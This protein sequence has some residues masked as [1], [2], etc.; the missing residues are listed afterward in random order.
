MCGITVSIAIGKRNS[1][2][3]VNGS[4]N[5]AAKGVVNGAVHEQTKNGIK[6]SFVS[7][8][9]EENLNKSLDLLAHRGPDA[10]GIWINK[11]GTVGLAHNR[12]SIND[13]SPDGNQPLHSDDGTIHAVVNGEIYDYDRIRAMLVR[14]HGYRFKSR[15]DSELVVAL[16]K[17]FGAPGFLEH[18]RGEF[19]FVIYD[20]RTERI[21]AA[22]DRFGI[23]P[24]FWTI[25]GEGVNRRLL[26][27]AEAK[28]FLALGWK[29]KWDVQA[30]FDSGWAS[31]DRTLF[32]GVR[33]VLPSYW[34]EVSAQGE[35]QHHRYWDIDYSDKNEVDTRSVEEM[36]QGVR[37]RLME[38]IRLRLRADVPVGILLSGGLDSS[39]VAGIV[40]HLVREEGAKHGN[41]DPTDRISCFT[42]QFPGA[43]YDESEIA[44]RTAKWLG[45]QIYKQPMNEAAMATHFADSAYYAEHHIFD[46]N[47]TAKFGLSLLP[48]EKGYKVV[49]TG[50]GSDE[51]FAGYPPFPADFLREPDLSFPSVAPPL[52][53]EM[54]KELQ[55]A[56]EHAIITSAERAGF[57]MENSEGYQQIGDE[58]G[59]H[60]MLNFI[61]RVQPPQ[62]LFAPWV[63]QQKWNSDVGTTILR[64]VEP[65]TAEKIANKWHSLH[66]SEYL[67]TR[68]A[69]P[70][71][72]L[73]GIGDRSEMGH[74]IEG[75]P[76]FLDHELSAY[77]NGLPPSTKL[78]YLP[79]SVRGGEER[80]SK[81]WFDSMGGPF[82]E[83]WILREAAKPFIT[84]EQYE[85]KKHPLS[86]PSKWSKGG[87]LNRMLEETC[88]RKAVEGL[89]FI[90]FNVVENALARGFGDD[91]DPRSFRLL[92]FVATWVILSQRFGMEKATAEA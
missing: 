39:L 26:I 28:A 10:R 15:S 84:Q 55:E 69:L 41:L 18:L 12:L 72:L 83:K 87:P 91:A 37:E 78:R 35:M 43:E 11:D 16:Y 17:A 53:A 89:G 52:E 8:E 21:I 56:D 76:P 7:Q 24:L 88:T 58:A 30:I 50:E 47:M 62:S 75:R 66:S 81:G 33:K 19:S 61:R 74:S 1:S 59:G 64:A 29:A 42:I 65:E 6:A 32:Q 34:M 79:A 70:N 51:H 71:L 3:R 85:R 45:V 57:F 5:G 77:V 27:A 82:I 60:E 68:S 2:T 31:D 14:E 46:L 36:V 9:L 4:A 20:E 38:A 63:R 54:R 90:D 73:S 86:A 40:T 92:L 44:E 80:I 22:R 25:V 23:K 48:L 67:W 49:L 13:L